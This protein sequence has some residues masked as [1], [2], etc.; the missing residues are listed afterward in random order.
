MLFARTVETS[1]AIE[2]II[3]AD[4]VLAIDVQYDVFQLNS[5]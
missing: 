1:S 3:V 2:G 5:I 4:I